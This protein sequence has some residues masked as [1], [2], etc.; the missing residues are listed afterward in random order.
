MGADYS[1]AISEEY[2]ETS[3]HIGLWNRALNPKIRNYASTWIAA[4]SS[5]ARNDV[6]SCVLSQ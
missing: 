2:K 6:K 4:R 1:K 5:N 3:I